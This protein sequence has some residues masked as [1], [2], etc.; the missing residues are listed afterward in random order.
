MEDKVREFLENNFADAVIRTEIF[1]N[2]LSVYIRKE[3]LFDICQ[4]LLHDEALG[5]KFLSD[6]CSLD[7]LGQ[8]EEAEGR[9]EVIYNLFSLKYRYRFFI[10]VKLAGENPE[11]DSLTPLWNTADWLEREVY[12]LMGITFSGH[13]DLRKIVTPDDLEGHPLRKDFPLTYETPQ[14]S[15]NKT[16]PPEVII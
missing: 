5:F 12:D 10:R 14:F 11:I 6:I 9:F 8:S 7:W 1:R 2:Q 3:Y 16:E 4:A 13:P 15:H